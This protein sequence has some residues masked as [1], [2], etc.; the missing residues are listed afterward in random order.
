VERAICIL[1]AFSPEAPERGVSELSQDLGLHKSTVSRLM[2][3]L[4]RGGLLSRNPQTRRYRLGIDL[5]GMA[6]QVVSHIDVREVAR[7]ILREL[8]Q[9]CQ[10]S[11][12]LVV[13]DQGQVVN[14]E[15]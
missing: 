13:M 11:V 6:G 10:E 4:E 1:K 8:A 15:Q 7:P 14:L 2:S 9:E 3:T 12:N 5:I